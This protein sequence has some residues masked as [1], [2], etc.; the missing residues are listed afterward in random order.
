MTSRFQF[1]DVFSEQAFAGN[2]LAVVLDANDL[3]TR[4]YATDHSLDEPVR[5]NIPAT[6]NR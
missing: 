3:T 6:G 2:P 5:D 1:V 4:R